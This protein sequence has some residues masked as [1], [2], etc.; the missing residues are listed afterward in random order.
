VN[1]EKKTQ[2]VE[3]MKQ[4]LREQTD[5]EVINVFYVEL[6]LIFYFRLEN[7]SIRFLASSQEM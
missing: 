1:E 5:D 7:Q 4:I 2:I 3:R 6:N